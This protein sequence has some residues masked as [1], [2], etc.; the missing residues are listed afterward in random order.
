[1]D[2]TSAAMPTITIKVHKWQAGW[3]G[4]IYRQNAN[5]IYV[6]LRGKG[7]SAVGNQ[8]FNW[9]FG[10]VFAVPLGVRAQHTASSD[11]VLVA[12]SDEGP[13][14]FSGYYSLEAC[15]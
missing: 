1:V 5:V 11:A 8:Q 14:K 3:E 10:D 4:K 13:M 15:E 6:V 7:C 12:L 9:D 2:F